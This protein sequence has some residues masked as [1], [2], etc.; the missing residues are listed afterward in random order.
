MG[1]TKFGNVGLRWKKR[2]GP[3]KDIKGDFLLGGWVRIGDVFMLSLARM[4]PAK[5][6]T[7]RHEEVL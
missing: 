5:A 2:R 3:L 4:F 1:I 6:K 7:C